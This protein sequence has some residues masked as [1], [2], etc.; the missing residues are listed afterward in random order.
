MSTDPG[1]DYKGDWSQISF[2]TELVEFHC[3]LSEVA[4]KSSS[5]CPGRG[6]DWGVLVR[7]S[8]CM[9]ARVYV[10]GCVDLGLRLSVRRPVCACVWS[11]T[12]VSVCLNMSVYLFHVCSYSY[13]SPLFFSLSLS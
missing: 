10:Y 12:S 8:V 6:V 5:P 4:W 13:P 2:E 1:A 7:G 11:H 9:C 3:P